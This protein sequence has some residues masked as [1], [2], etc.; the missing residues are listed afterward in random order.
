MQNQVLQADR[1]RA[2]HAPREAE[3]L[4]CEAMG[5][6]GDAWVVLEVVVYAE[7]VADDAV[8]VDVDGVVVGEVVDAVGDWAGVADL[9]AAG[10]VGNC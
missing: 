8:V 7:V 6:V 3:V 10:L 9:G 2:Y 5:S 1:E 4:V